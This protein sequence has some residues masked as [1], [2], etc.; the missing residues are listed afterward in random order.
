VSRAQG[1]LVQLGRE[2]IRLDVAT[3]RGAER[4]VIV[5]VDGREHHFGA[6]GLGSGGVFTYLASYGDEGRE[7]FYWSDDIRESIGDDYAAIDQ[8]R[9]GPVLSPLVRTALDSLARTIGGS[10]HKGFM[11]DEKTWA[12]RR[13]RALHREAREQFDPAEIEVWA[14]TNGW[15]LRD[16][17]ALRTIA[18]GVLEGKSFRGVDRRAIPY[19]REQ[20]RRM[21]AQ[22]RAE[23][24]EAAEPPV[25]EDEHGELRPDPRYVSGAERED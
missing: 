19:D 21:V 20:A 11:L 14:A 16:A 22:W 25:Y 2:T 7:K 24:A 8:P 1:T 18:E 12:V 6:G 9:L 13:L 17:R 4:L 10:K 5:G 15:S 3:D 23:R